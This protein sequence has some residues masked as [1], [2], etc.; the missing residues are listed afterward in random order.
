MP[1]NSVNN[2]VFRIGFVGSM[3]MITK[4][5]NFEATVLSKESDQSETSPLQRV[6]KKLSEKK[7]L[8]EP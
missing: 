8:R 6:S 1:Y 4:V 5:E 2:L 3:Q 7:S